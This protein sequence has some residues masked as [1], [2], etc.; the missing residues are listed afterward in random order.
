MKEIDYLNVSKSIGTSLLNNGF[1][2]DSVNQKNY[3]TKNALSGIEKKNP[4]IFN[5]RKKIMSSNKN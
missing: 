3:S 1:Q 4:I 2:F 5:N